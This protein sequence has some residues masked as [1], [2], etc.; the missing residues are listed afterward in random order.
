MSAVIIALN[1]EHRIA[2]CLESVAFADEVVVVDSGSTDATLV[3]AKRYGAHIV[4]QTWLGFGKQ[5]QFAVGQARHRW[6]LCVD[7]DERVSPP[8][9]QSIQTELVAPRFAAYRMARCNRFMGRWLRHGEGYPDW[10]LRLFNREQATWSDDAVHERVVTTAPVGRLSGDLLHDT[11]SGIGNYLDK[12]NRYTSLQ[13]ET[14]YQR[15][16]RAGRVRLVFSPL[17]RFVKFYFL[18][19]GFLDGIPGFVHISIG[20]YNSFLKYAKLMELNR[21]RRGTPNGNTGS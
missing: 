5:K 20:C 1:V 10:C 17:L 3:I 12:Q 4:H 16:A 14:L 7:A 13:A 18:R 21:G 11:D 2:A 9:R 15:G 19:A 8:L 6:V